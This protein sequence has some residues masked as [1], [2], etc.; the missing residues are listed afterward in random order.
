[1][2][3]G[4][5]FYFRDRVGACLTDTGQL[6]QHGAGECAIGVHVSNAR[7][8]QAVEPTRDHVAFLG[9]VNLSAVDA[10]FV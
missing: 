6:P 4:E 10:A 3:F 1:M 5:I 7:V 2:Q 8:D 9:E